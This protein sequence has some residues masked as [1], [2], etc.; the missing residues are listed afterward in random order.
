M[1][2][3]NGGVFFL[4]KFQHKVQIIPLGGLGGNW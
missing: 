1:K 2:I 3:K 4:G